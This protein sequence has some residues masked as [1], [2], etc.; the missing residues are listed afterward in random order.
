MNL[1]QDDYKVLLLA[2]IQHLH[3]LVAQ[4]DDAFAKQLD[5]VKEI[6]AAYAGAV[7][8]VQKAA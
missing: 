3:A 6:A 5:R 8:L 4:S 1:S 2:N 7:K